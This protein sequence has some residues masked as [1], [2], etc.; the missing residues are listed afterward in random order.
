VLELHIPEGA[1]PE[2]K[3]RKLATGVHEA[4]AEVNRVQFELNMKIT[5]LQLKWQPMTLLEV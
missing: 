2:E 1:Q 4:K 3:I 5:E